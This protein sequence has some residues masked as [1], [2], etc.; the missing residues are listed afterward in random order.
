MTTALVIQRVLD[1]N[2]KP[3]D[4]LIS[5]ATILFWVVQEWVLHKYILHE[6]ITGEGWVGYNIHKNHHSLPYY[7]VSLDGPEIAIAWGATIFAFSHAIFPGEALAAHRLDFL[8]TYF[9]MGLLY[10][11][12]HYLTHTRYVP[13]TR[14]VK[15]SKKLD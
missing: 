13:K 8:L 11:W 14:F 6:P 5:G 2:L 15:G 4:F 12:T 3:T 1:G 7:H 9:T 10:E